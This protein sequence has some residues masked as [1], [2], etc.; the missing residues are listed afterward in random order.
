M[1]RKITLGAGAAVRREIAFI[2][3]IVA[4]ASAPEFGGCGVRLEAAAGALERATD[5]LLT[6]APEAALA[7][8]YSYL[9][10]FGIAL[11]GACLVKAGLA[12]G[13]PSRVA[14]ARF[15]VETQG[16]LAPGLAEAVLLAGGALADLKEFA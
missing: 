15:F 16:P 14:L 7:G 8:A 6:A 11:G 4:G 2:R 1:T 10:L 5:Y 13:E 9:K 12:E 3:E